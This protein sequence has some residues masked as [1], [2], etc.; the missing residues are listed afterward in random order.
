MES[1]TKVEAK[2]EGQYAM[3]FSRAPKEKLDYG[4]FVRERLARRRQEST[5]TL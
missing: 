5:R 1:I 3:N 4:E 2:D